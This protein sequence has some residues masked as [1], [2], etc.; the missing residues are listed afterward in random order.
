MAFDTHNN[1]AY[2]TVL[3]GGVVGSTTG[4]TIQVQNGNGSLFSINQNITVSPPGVQPLKTNSEIMRIT[5]IDLDILTVLRAQEGSTVQG[6]IASGYLVA[7]TITAKEL[8]DIETQTLLL[9]GGT[10]TG[11]ITSQNVIPSAN[12]TYNLGSTSD[13]YQYI[14]G[15]RLYLQLY[16]LS[17][18]GNG[19]NGSNK[20]AFELSSSTQ[21]TP[22]VVIL[23]ANTFYWLL[24][25]WG[26]TGSMT[27]MRSSL[28]HNNGQVQEQQLNWCC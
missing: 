16:S 8:T 13:Y 5:V 18:W 11:D 2:S 27:S 12:T 24:E 9:A 26:S 21:Q 7:N 28:L 17:G 25:Y 22:L 4:T 20:R 15:S 23:F 6:N 10:M 14:Y 3:G 19:R 1:F